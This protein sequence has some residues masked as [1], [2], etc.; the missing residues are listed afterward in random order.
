MALGQKV[1]PEPQNWKVPSCL[2]FCG[3]RYGFDIEDCTGIMMLAWNS[4]TRN[5]RTTCVNY[6][7]LTPV[8]EASTFE[9]L[10][11]MK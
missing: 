11:S 8:T 4:Y 3:G 1:I 5:F 10:E 6:L 7:H 2:N 9:R